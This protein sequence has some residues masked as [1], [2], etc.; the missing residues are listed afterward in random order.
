M[1]ISIVVPLFSDHRTYVDRLPLQRRQWVSLKNQADPDF[2][3][4]LVDNASHDDVLGLARE[5]FPGAVTLRHETPKNTTGARCAG[6]R[7]A[8]NSVVV[9]LDSDCI[10]YPT[11]IAHWKRFA[12]VHGI[13]SVGVGG[14]YWYN[15]VILKDHEFLHGLQGGEEVDYQELEAFVRKTWPGARPR[16][17][18]PASLL[19]ESSGRSKPIPFD[20]RGGFY[21]SNACFPRELY[22]KIG[23]SDADLVG[24]GHDDT[25]FG[26]R[27]QATKTSV[28]FVTGIPV[29]HQCHRIAGPGD[30]SHYEDCK[31]ALEH[32]P[33]VE[34]LRRGLR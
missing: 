34:E 5:Y 17:P 31:A 4:V 10:V 8:S 21:Y 23:E 9:T 30:A 15:R 28:Y 2:E 33:L 24:Y 3:L 19:R 32:A 1:K 7:R 14:F 20:W 26:L 12:A 27:L 6:V 22:L 11:F 18:M 13:R 25:L 16:Y 29:I